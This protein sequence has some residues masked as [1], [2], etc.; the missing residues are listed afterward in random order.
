M[1]ETLTTNAT[2]PTVVESAN[3]SDV[4]TAGYA[5][6]QDISDGSQVVETSTPMDNNVTYDNVPDAS[7]NIDLNQTLGQNI[8]QRAV[9]SSYQTNLDANSGS[10][11]DQFLSQDYDYDKKEAGT[12]WVAGAINDVETQM[13]FLNT[14]I[15]EDMYDVMD[16][17]KYY[18][19]TTMATARAYAAS[20]EKE[21]AYGL[22]RAAQEKAIAEAQLTGWYMPAEGNYMLAQYAVAQNV[23]NS[24]AATNDEIARASRISGTV[25]KWFN[26]NQIGT[27]GI[28]CL[29]L[30]NH[31]ENVRHN[32]IMGELQKE[33]NQLAGQ[34]NG[35]NAA[36]NDLKL[37]E[38]RFQM[39][40]YELA[41]GQNITKEIGLDNDD[42]LGHDIKN[43]P[44][45]EKWQ[46]LRGGNNLQEILQNEDSFSSIL[47]V[48]NSKWLEDSLG[49]DNYK[50]TKGRYDAALGQKKLQTATEKGGNTLS[51]EDL[52][53][54]KFKIASGETGAGK[55][56]YTFTTMEN[57]KPVTKVY[58]K[59]GD[60]FKQVTSDVKLTGDKKI[61]DVA[62][63]FSSTP[64]EYNNQ[65]IAVGSFNYADQEGTISSKNGYK[66]YSKKQ[67][68]TMQEKQEQGWKVVD[69]TISTQKQNSSVVMSKDIDGVTKYY[70]VEHNGAWHEITDTEKIHSITISGKEGDTVFTVRENAFGNPDHT[71]STNTNVMKE[72]TLSGKETGSANL[73]D[74]SH[75]KQVHEQFRSIGT[76]FDGS[77]MSEVVSYTNPDG[78]TVYLE[79]KETGH[80]N[81]N[82]YTYKIIS[83]ERAAE[84]T[85]KSVD[86]LSGYETSRDNYRN[87]YIPAKNTTT[88]STTENNKVSVST[89]HAAMNP[90]KGYEAQD[91]VNDRQAIFE[92][93]NV[94]LGER[95]EYID[96]LDPKELEEKIK[97]NHVSYYGSFL[98]KE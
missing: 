31:E 53:Q 33:A 55:D 1:D 75:G 88:E 87:S 48:R 21:T 24:D 36:A 90:S 32:T 23:L 2:E 60:V 98:G 3:T 16:L 61:S 49:A 43:N 39:E 86:T 65:G 37:R 28:K 84:L 15:R 5:Q 83:K 72:T 58:Y 94:P 25:E 40:E 92:K 34:A 52:N 30:L 46:A 56:I 76:T 82:S 51:E 78:S 95:R 74:G 97:E 85:G 63:N 12:Y 59:D 71:T 62:Y 50:E 29:N 7:Q 38:F 44:E 93:Y 57:G 67:N 6:T 20:K 47:G 17:Q 35:I 19:D 73:W 91:T 81:G 8:L 64:L 54:T 27:R 80:V 68:A 45:Y 77:R 41:T 11:M 10:A 13:T 14:L 89:S 79:G 9:Q 70:E 18:Y 69:G 26:A 22:Y 96:I 4:N 42:F 66:N